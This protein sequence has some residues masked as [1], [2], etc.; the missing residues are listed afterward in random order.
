MPIAVVA[1][2]DDP[3][4]AGDAAVAASAAAVMMASKVS[5]EIVVVA[6]CRSGTRRNCR[7]GR[8]LE[9]ND[10]WGSGSGHP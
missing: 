6:I 3:R 5:G 7:A 2:A 8:L 9:G 4:P 1:S 10:R